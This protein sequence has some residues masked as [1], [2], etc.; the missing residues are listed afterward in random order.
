MCGGMGKKG[1]WNGQG[2]GEEGEGFHCVGALGNVCIMILTAS[3]LMCVCVW[4]I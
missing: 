3:R 4:C 2:R 1:K